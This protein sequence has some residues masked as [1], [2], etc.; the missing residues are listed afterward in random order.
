M[1]G[2]FFYAY[3]KHQCN[4]ITNYDTITLNM[5]SGTDMEFV[6]ARNSVIGSKRTRIGSSKDE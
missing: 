2:L 5:F 1:Q 4:L 6:R 3:Y